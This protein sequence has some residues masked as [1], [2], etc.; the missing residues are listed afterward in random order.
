ML[1]P[2][3]RRNVMALFIEFEGFVQETKPFSWGNVAKIAHNQRA[4]NAAGEWETT[5]KDYIDVVLPDGVVV[6]D[7]SLVKVSG[8]FKVSSYPKKDGTFG[9]A[10]KVNAREIVPVVRRNDPIAVVKEVLGAEFVDD[11]L[12]F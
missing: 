4:K 6:T 10:I 9:V 3:E 7:S 8:T 1:D 5:G 11:G 2:I 12:P